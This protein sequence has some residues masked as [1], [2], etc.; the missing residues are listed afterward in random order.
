MARNGLWNDQKTIRYDQNLIIPKFYS[1]KPF[2]SGYFRQF[3]GYPTQGRKG[4]Y[5]GTEKGKH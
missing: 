5:Y 2:C 4:Y 3:P 1:P